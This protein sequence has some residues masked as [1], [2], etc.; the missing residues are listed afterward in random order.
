MN[1]TRLIALLMVV[2]AAAGIAWAFA[3]AR[4]APP[5]MNAV[6]E[7]RW[8]ANGIIL[9][10]AVR[11]AATQHTLV[12]GATAR[13]GGEADQVVDWLDIAPAALPVADA[14]AL[15]SLIRLGQEGWH[16]QRKTDSGWLAVQSPEDGR[17]AQAGNLLQRA[18][19]SGVAI[20]LVPLP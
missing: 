4:P 2:L 6:L 12:E 10:G 8:H 17:S 5:A 11:D 18:F 19:G 14:A 9:Q 3:A 7:I 15:A 16:L 20:R 1:R 13:L